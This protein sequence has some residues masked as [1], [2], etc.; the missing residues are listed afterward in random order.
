MQKK[1][2]DYIAFANTKQPQYEKKN[3]RVRWTIIINDALQK[4]SIGNKWETGEKEKRK[5]K[6]ENGNGTMK[7]DTHSHTPR[8]I[9]NRRII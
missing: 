8:K 1:T 7:N 9:C 4:Q 5:N 6:N 3:K 2:T